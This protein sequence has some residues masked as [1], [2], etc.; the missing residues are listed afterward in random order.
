M[1]WVRARRVW[2]DA[3]HGLCAMLR[4]GALRGVRRATQVMAGSMRSCEGPIVV[5][6]AAKR[7]SER[8]IGQTA[9][10]C[11]RGCPLPGAPSPKCSLA[12]RTCTWRSMRRR[13][14]RAAR[15]RRHTEARWG[16]RST[17]RC[18]LYILLVPSQ[19]LARSWRAHYARFE[20]VQIDTGKCT[21]LY[22]YMNASCE[23]NASC[24]T[25]VT[26]VRHRAV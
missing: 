18:R 7:T 6:A 21:R 2:Y 14:A 22:R 9:T 8:F 3:V 11:R 25:G 5:P 16:T 17:C 24:M 19:V 10:N 4:Y 23:A 12:C 1:R 26:A 13:R 15:A 20:R